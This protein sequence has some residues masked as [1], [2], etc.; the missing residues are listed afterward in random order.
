MMTIT[1]SFLYISLQISKA[2]EKNKTTMQTHYEQVA[3]DN[4]SFWTSKKVSIWENEY[5]EYA[6]LNTYENTLG[7]QDSKTISFTLDNTGSLDIVSGWPI[8][9][10][11]FSGSTV[12]NS[13]LCITNMNNIP[14]KGNI[15]LQNLWWLT[16]FS[17]ELET[18][19]GIVFPDNYYKRIKNI[20]W[21]DLIQSTIFM[22]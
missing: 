20:G 5:V 13:G 18:A 16:Q 4:I 22:K 9:Y 10:K 21:T 2:I 12:Y 7:W 11:V 6:Y 15:Q 14:I 17:L 3:F 19:S 1:S 8:Y